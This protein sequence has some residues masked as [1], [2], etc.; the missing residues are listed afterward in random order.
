VI[1]N[2]IKTII[3]NFAFAGSYDSCEEIQS[4]NVHNT[5]CIHYSCNEVHKRYILQRVNTYVFKEPKSVMKNIILITDHLRK[6]IVRANEDPTRRV[7]DIIPTI[8]GEPL[9]ED[10]E[11][12]YWRGYGFI[13]NATAHD[14]VADARMAYEIGRGFGNFQKLLVDFPAG[15]LFTPIPDFHN[16]PKRFYALM[17]SIDQDRINR[18]CEVENEI[19]FMFD[20]RR[21]MSEIVKLLDSGVLPLRVTHNDTKSNNVLVD[22]DTLKAICVIDLD[23]VMPGSVLYD[24]GDA[25]RFCASAAAEDERDESKVMLEME[26]TEQFTRGFVEETN[27]FL[28]RA[29]LSRL[30]LGIKVITCEL[31]MRFLTDYLDG[32]LYFKVNSTDH[33]LVRARA[34]I[35][36]LR[37]IEEKEQEIQ[38][39][40]YKYIR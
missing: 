6:S 23:T 16:T 31:A 18:V 40:V 38:N 35:A 19:E 7:L 27:G 32:D 9:Y 15:T 14:T 20:H 10:G 21:M 22:N 29:E 11:G 30:P 1:Y 24:Y 26:K 17:R 25:V 28:T 4:G 33:N 37:D 34:Q 3:P 8:Q 5:Y 12:G 13:D 36:L 2:L 39:L